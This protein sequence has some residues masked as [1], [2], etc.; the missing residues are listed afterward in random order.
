MGNTCYFG[1]SSI[2]KMTAECSPLCRVFCPLGLEPLTS[3]VGTLGSVLSGA[4]SHRLAI[5]TQAL[6]PGFFTS[7]VDGA[8]SPPIAPLELRFPPPPPNRGDFLFSTKTRVVDHKPHPSKGPV[9]R[10]WFSYISPKVDVRHLGPTTANKW[11]R[12]KNP[13]SPDCSLAVLV[14]LY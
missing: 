5:E 6:E 14:A 4:R 7:G 2:L 3:W 1:G 8:P 12:S 11:P 13:I 10:G 9:Y